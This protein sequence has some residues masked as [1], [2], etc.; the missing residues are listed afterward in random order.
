MDDDRDKARR[1]AAFEALHAIN[2]RLVDEHPQALAQADEQLS[3]AQMGLSNGAVADRRD[4]CFGLYPP[5]KLEA[6]ARA[7]ANSG[8]TSVIQQ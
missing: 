7:I 4:W 5:R 8:R 3:E 6:L 2:D 1:R